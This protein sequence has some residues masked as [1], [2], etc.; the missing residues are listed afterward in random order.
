MLTLLAKLFHA[1]N[2]E[3]STRQIALA[4]TL[5]FMAGLA[6][7]LTLQNL[8]LLLLVMLIR[9]HLGA[10]ILSVGV[11]SGVGYL[12]SGI[13]VGIGE[14]LLTSAV[15]NGLFTSLYQLSVFKLGHWHH[16]YTL[17]ALVV[18]LAL[19]APVYFIF[20]GLIVKY[21]LH[22]K[23]AVEKFKIV[24]ALKG[25]NFYRLYLQFSGQGG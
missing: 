21:R 4:I 3:S 16:T 10:F 8:I 6:P 19:A 24:R 14:S 22:I 1:L 15:L 13:I 18:G 12:L 11:F 23:T 9:V 25:S 17:G 20:Q 7:L 2:S 5:G